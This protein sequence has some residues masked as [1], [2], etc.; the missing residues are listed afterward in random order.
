MQCAISLSMLS[1][2]RASLSA[3][4]FEELVFPKGNMDLLRF[5]KEE[6]GE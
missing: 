3:T 2:L 1:L 5:K 6:E 4:H